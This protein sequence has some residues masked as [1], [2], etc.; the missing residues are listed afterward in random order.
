MH[1]SKQRIAMW[2]CPRSLSTALM[3]A[4]ESRI[5]TTVWDEPLYPAYLHETG[6]TPPHT[7]EIMATY[8]TDWRAV[9]QQM[10]HGTKSQEQP[11]AYYKLISYNYLESMGTAWLTDLKNAFLIR[12][13]HDQILSL[14]AKG[15]NVTT[16]RTGLPRLYYIFQH[17]KQLTGSIPP[18]IDARDLQNQP[19]KTLKRLCEALEVSFDPAMLTW[20]DGERTTDGLWSRHWYDVVTQSKRFLPYKPKTT[21]MPDTL[22]PVLKACQ[23]IYQQLY[24]HRL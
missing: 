24:T 15:E 20:P 12:H 1:Q 5:D 16:E 19:E 14:H 21:P 18:V 3:R 10:C 4:W 2:S 9:I 23:E 13:P 17:V 7:K 8:E 22:K 6:E 11:I